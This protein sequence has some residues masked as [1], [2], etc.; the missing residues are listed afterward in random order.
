M[1]LAIFLAIMFA[2]SVSQAKT[3]TVGTPEY[4]PPFVM[5]SDKNHYIGFDVDILTEICHR[6]STPCTFIP[7][8][9]GDIF[10]DLTNGRIDLAIGGVTITLARDKQ[11]LFSLPY[12]PSYGQYVVKYGSKI[13]R[14]DDTAGKTVGVAIESAYEDLLTNKLGKNVTIKT[15]DFHS[16]L[17]DALTSN[18]VDAIL[19]DRASAESWFANTTNSYTLLGKPIPIGFGYGILANKDANE[20]ITQINKALLSMEADGTYLKIYEIYFNL[21]DL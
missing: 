17:F 13:Q 16:Q 15:Y 4:N 18:E 20:L 5:A 2:L 9:F 14:I 6:I 10:T 8:A 7:L 1:R 11:F 12:L 19:T 21:R 3:L